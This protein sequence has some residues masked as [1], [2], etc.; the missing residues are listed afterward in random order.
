MN[1]TSKN[2]WPARYFS[3]FS[4]KWSTCILGDYI[5]KRKTP[6][7]IE[8]SLIYQY[9]VCHF[10]KLPKPRFLEETIRWTQKK[11]E[12]KYRYL[13]CTR[14]MPIRESYSLRVLKQEYVFTIRQRVFGVCVQLSCSI[15]QWR[16]IEGRE[17]V[18]SV[19]RGS[20]YI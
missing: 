18:C 1:T 2:F 10:R 6:S 9:R 4:S 8:L 5:F 7:C 14:N 13:C 16:L 3:I 11:H 17:L 20:T 12:G 19:E 15:V